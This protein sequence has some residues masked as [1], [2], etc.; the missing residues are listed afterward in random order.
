MVSAI[1]Q[2]VSQTSEV[3]SS[4][5]GLIKKNTWYASP[6]LEMYCNYPQAFCEYLTPPNVK[7][8]VLCVSRNKHEYFDFFLP[9]QS[10][11]SREE[12]T[13]RT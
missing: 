13:K 1:S 11:V 2:H 4:G 10:E 3:F 5:E 6:L 7:Q 8:G 9:I 12:E